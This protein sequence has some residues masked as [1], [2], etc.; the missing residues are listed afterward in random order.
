MIKGIPLNAYHNQAY[1]KYYHNS[2]GKYKKQ[3][4]YYKNNYS[5]LLSKELLEEE[6]PTEETIKKIK[7]II[8]LDRVE[9]YSKKYNLAV[10]P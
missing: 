6:N 3:H 9:K 4:R 1:K 10:N 7:N 8:Y 2:N 5:N